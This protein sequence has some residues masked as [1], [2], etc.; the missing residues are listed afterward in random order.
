[1]SG[2]FKENLL[3]LDFG[4]SSSIDRSLLLL[5]QKDDVNLSFSEVFALEDAAKFEATA[6]YFRH[7]PD[8]RSPIPQIYIYDN[9][10]NI[11]NEDKLA[12][13]HRDLWSNCRIPMFIVIGKTGIEIFDSRK[14]V[15]IVE[16]K[17]KTSP[18][19]KLN[20][21]S[22]AV[23]EYQKLKSY[24][25]EL[26]DSGVFWEN[27]KVKGHFL[28]S[29]SAYRDLINNLK[30]IREEF[31]KRVGLPEKIAHK[32][33]VFG[34]LIKYLE[35]R[36][37]ENG[38]L[39]AKNFFSEFNAENFCGVLRQKGKIISLF[40]KLSQKFNGKIFEWANDD[41]EQI[42]EKA[43]LTSLAEFLDA[44][45]QMTT[46]QGTLF[47]WKLYS[48]NHL[49]IELISSVYEE[50]LNNE[51]GVVYTPEFL[52]N[53]LIDESM[54]H[55][56]YEKTDF[57]TIDV[58]CGSGIFLVSAFKTLVQRHR[59]SKFKETGKL[60]KLNSNE[61]LSVIKKNIFGIDIKDDARNLTV[62][63]L[64]LALCD[65][66]TPPQIWEELKFDKTFQDNFKTANYFEYVELPEN[67][68][69]FDLVIG[70]PPFISLSKD[71]NGKYFK[72]KIGNEQIEKYYGTYKEK[73]SG[74]K[75]VKKKMYVNDDIVG[76]DKKKIFP[77]NQT[78][79]MFLEQSTLLLKE[80]GL[81]CL[82]M[83][84][85]P[86]L[87]NNS[88][89]FRKYFFQKYQVSQILDFTNLDSVLFE[90]DV[91]TAAIF[92]HK[93]EHD[94]EKSITH[95][96]IRRTKTNEDK[97]FF[98]IDKYDFHYVSKMEAINDKHIWKCNLLGGGRLHNLVTRLSYSPSIKD[99]IE[100]NKW[101]YGVGYE[102][103]SLGKQIKTA[104]YITGNPSLPTP[105]LTENGIDKNQIFTE[106]AKKFHRISNEKLFTPPHLL[107]K[108]NIGKE[109]IPTYFSDDYLTF[110][111]VILG[112][113]APEN[114]RNELL[115]LSESIDIHKD[116]YRFL[117]AAT[118][119][120]YLVSRETATLNQDFLNLPYPQDKEDLQLS[121]V[122]QILCDDVLDYYIQ[123]KSESRKAKMNN[124]ADESNLKKYGE[125]FNKLLNSVYGKS[126]KWL[127][128]NK[129]YDS[130]EFYITEF[131]YGDEIKEV[132]FEKTDKIKENLK[133]I[134]INELG[135][136]FHLQRVIRINERNK[137][138]F[139]K[140]KNLRYWL[141]SIAIKD[142]DEVFSGLVK[143]GY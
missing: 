135:T 110:K 41:E 37:N 31:I 81:V 9:S 126:G 141:R 139:I 106:T 127:Y 33:L 10:D 49:P 30:Y 87:Y 105:T 121:Y 13:I 85:A 102:I 130:G 6:V 35:E 61:L 75:E 93:Q 19:D 17:L 142:A 114:E 134:I 92:V 69:K 27:D 125:V 79:L 117:I 88:N 73:T 129:I 72:E 98:E 43:D 94:E 8:N 132:E 46:R 44:D 71:K 29:T 77:D 101:V 140:P 16:G 116:I 96:T 100:A 108:T 22:D 78:A 25:K 115:E 21:A 89:E 59:F 58:S 123:I 47:G 64:C 7:F 65:E 137:F 83:P 128:L 138:T 84:S 67:H 18:I 131:N 50:F 90:A 23:A 119:N 60:L 57:K 20:L 28:E 136:N 76:K 120:K 42:I 39:F 86:L 56:D 82:I 118:S 133:S 54:P 122:E 14:P 11:L 51:K 63:S 99:F 80:N 36:G 66:L 143:A 91:P 4:S 70:N 107:I 38:G 1:V 109:K 40:H 62:F 5:S 95:I 55:K 45:F 104:A 97:I 15:E 2:L 53:T 48:F 3:K 103:G 12:E 68:G 112:V 32:L 26:F 74:G 24:S 52:V 34:I 113:S 111:K 124:F